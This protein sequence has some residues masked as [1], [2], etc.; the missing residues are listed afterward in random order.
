MV[1]PSSLQAA[2]EACVRDFNGGVKMIMPYFNHV[3]SRTLIVLLVFNAYCMSVCGD[4]YGICHHNL[5]TTSILPG[6]KQSGKLLDYLS[7]HIVAFLNILYPLHPY[8]PRFIEG[9]Y[10]LVTQLLQVK[11]EF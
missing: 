5:V 4:V 2:T 8:I 3:S 7:E 1:G 9:S 10:A 11:T 6:E